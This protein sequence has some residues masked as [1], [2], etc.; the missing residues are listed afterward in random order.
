MGCTRIMVPKR[1]FFFFQIPPHPSGNRNKRLPS[2]KLRKTRDTR[3]KNKK[4][5]CLERG[6]PAVYQLQTR[7]IPS[8]P[9]DR[10]GFYHVSRKFLQLFTGGVPIPYTCIILDKQK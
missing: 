7:G 10:F 6:N 3:R 1:D 5:G 8:L 9:Y 4:P 2:A